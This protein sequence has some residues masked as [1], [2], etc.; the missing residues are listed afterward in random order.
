MLNA[1]CLLVLPALTQPAAYKRKT[2]TSA[3]STV[4]SVLHPELGNETLF[5]VAA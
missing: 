5:R 3:F 1:L 4:I 2:V